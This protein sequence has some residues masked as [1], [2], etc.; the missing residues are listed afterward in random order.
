MAPRYALVTGASSGIGAATARA[1]ASEGC[2]VWITYSS[3]RSEA[4]ATARDC[5]ENGAPDAQVTKLDLRRPDSIAALIA[6][7]DRAWG[8]L[9]VLVN[10]AAICNYTKYD[11]IGIDEWDETMETN[12][13]G[14]FLLS[15]AA[16][17]LLRKGE[18]DRSIINVASVA[19][20]IG[21]VTTGMH[22]AASK[23]AILA[24]TRSLARALA[25]EGIRV[26]AVTP[27][28]I[29]S[30]ITEKLAPTERISLAAVIPLGRFGSPE[31]AAW[32]I[33]AAASPRASFVTG[34]TY[35]VNGGVRID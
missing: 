6:D 18:G 2:S 16:L 14:T 34:A 32:I 28:P 23:G 25:T 21:S 8:K 10:N 24:I 3:N 26:N 19:G 15:R 4:D 11:E 5:I 17:P 9:T 13:R 33:A 22:Y 30:S 7:I 31:E 35:D 12:A 1:L 20:Q 27:G 29:L